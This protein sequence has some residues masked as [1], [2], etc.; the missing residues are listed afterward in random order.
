M[1]KRIM[2]PAG[3]YIVILLLANIAYVIPSGPCDESIFLGYGDSR[4]VRQVH[5]SSGDICVSFEA[6][7][8][9]PSFAYREAYINFRQLGNSTEFAKGIFPV[10]KDI[11]IFSNDS[12]VGWAIEV[13]RMRRGEDLYTIVIGLLPHVL[14]ASPNENISSLNVSLTVTI[15]LQ[16]YKIYRIG[17]IK[18]DKVVVTFKDIN[19]TI[20]ERW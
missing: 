12:N 2:I 15:K 13:K 11:Q 10:I 5:T 20:V 4:A 14:K 9:Y 6:Y 3:V 17:F 8:S 1:R 7:S 18:R 16:V 19:T